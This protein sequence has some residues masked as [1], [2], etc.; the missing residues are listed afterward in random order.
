MIYVRSGEPFIKTLKRFQK[1]I[2]KSGILRDVRQRQH[3]VK[4]S[5][6]RRRKRQA[7]QRQRDRESRG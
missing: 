7:A 2:E 5:E 3:Y 1:E 4:P 6:K